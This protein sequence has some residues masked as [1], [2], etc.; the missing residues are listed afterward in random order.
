MNNISYQINENFTHSST[1]ATA[2]DWVLHWGL[3]GVLK[4]P[5]TADVPRHWKFRPSLEPVN[6][7]PSPGQP[8]FRQSRARLSASDEH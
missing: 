1:L 6:H 7:K 8:T 4:R 3:R 5:N 2:A